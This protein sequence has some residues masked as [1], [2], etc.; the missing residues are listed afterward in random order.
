MDEKEKHEMSLSQA[1]DSSFVSIIEELANF[2]IH[3][4]VFFQFDSKPGKARKRWSCSLR[5]RDDD[6]AEIEREGETINEAAF[7]VAEVLRGTA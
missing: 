2:D 6:A 3:G 1:I 4:I 7:K 5:A